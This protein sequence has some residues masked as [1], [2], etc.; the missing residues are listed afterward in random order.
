[1][2]NTLWCGSTQIT[3]T[4]VETLKSIQENL[5]A[6]DIPFKFG[7]DSAGNYGYYKNN[8]DTITPFNSCTY[9]TFYIIKFN[10]SGSTYAGTEYLCQFGHEISVVSTIGWK[11]NIVICNNT[12]DFTYTGQNSGQGATL[13]V[14]QDVYVDGKKVA[15]GETII[16]HMFWG[17]LIGKQ[18]IIY[19]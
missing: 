16:S 7:V 8:E 3:G 6:D 1:M 15:A 18:Y 9:D 11:Q 10:G 14:L 5:Y 19:E 12:L 17:N 13:T 4:S 2:S